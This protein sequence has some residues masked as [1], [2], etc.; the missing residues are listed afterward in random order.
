MRV[1]VVMPAADADRL[2]DRVKECA[3]SIERDQL[4]DEWETVCLCLS[5]PAWCLTRM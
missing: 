3:E 4:G 1:S 2:R 5:G